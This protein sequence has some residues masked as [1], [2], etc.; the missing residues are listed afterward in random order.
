MVLGANKE[1]ALYSLKYCIEKGLYEKEYLET[2]VVL[3]PITYEDVKKEDI[4]PLLGLLNP[5]K[6]V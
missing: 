5:P 6:S 2:K 3:L 4:Q 1:N